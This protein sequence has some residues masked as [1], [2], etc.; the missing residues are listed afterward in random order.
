MTAAMSRARQILAGTTYLVTRRCSE[1]RFFLR[2]S[3]RVNAI[4]LF[5][6][7]VA[8]ERSGILLHA[9]CVLSNHWHIVLTD[10]GG[11]LPVFNQYVDSLVARAVNFVN[12]R[13]DH[14]WES[15]S[16]SAVQLETPATSVQKIAYTLANPVAAGLVRHAHEW[17]GLWSGVTRIG[18]EAIDV[19]RPADFFRDGKRKRARMPRSASLRLHL[20]PGFASAETF[21]AQL[22]QELQTA[23]EHAAHEVA[24]TRRSFLGAARVLAQNPLARPNTAGLPR[25]I[26]PRVASTDG[27]KRA[28]ALGRLAEFLSAYQEALAEWRRGVRDALFPPGTYLM[29]VL[30]GARCAAT[31]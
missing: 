15:G 20:P 7:A 3:E 23:E 9:Y 27:P 12:R 17:P 2:P 26:N 21:Q 19:E 24:S 31:T 11:R 30:H 8:A 28:E 4:I 5:L 16:Y 10:P 14:F 13:K 18:G 25:E 29:R 22:L 1:Q 6:L